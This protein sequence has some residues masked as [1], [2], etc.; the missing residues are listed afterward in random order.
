MYSARGMQADAIRVAKKHRPEVLG[1]LV[2]GKFSGASMSVSKTDKGG[3]G[4][5]V[6][7]EASSIRMCLLR[8]RNR[9]G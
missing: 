8:K 9:A 1:D 7:C 3:R 4:L 5:W 2:E 6:C